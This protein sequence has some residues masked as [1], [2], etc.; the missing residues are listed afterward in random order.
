MLGPA[1]V[2]GMF[3]VIE[4]HTA[5]EM[6]TVHHGAF[7]KGADL[8]PSEQ[9]LGRFGKPAGIFT[10]RETAIVRIL[11]AFP[12]SAPDFRIVGFP[13]KAVSVGGIIEQSLCPV[14]SLRMPQ[15][16]GAMDVEVLGEDLQKDLYRQ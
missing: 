11:I 6:I 8:L 15:H 13:G 9:L 16:I 12:H 7:Q 1:P 2:A 4:S 5:E 10:F 3:T 14:L